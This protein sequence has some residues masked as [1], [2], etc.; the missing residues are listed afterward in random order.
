V[1]FWTHEGRRSV[2]L[3]ISYMTVAGV[4]DGNPVTIERPVEFFLA[5]GQRDMGQQWID[6]SLRM[7]SMAARSGVSVARTIQNMREVNWDKGAVRYGY[8][9]KDDGTKIP[10]FHESEVAALGFAVQEM[11]ANR[12]FLDADGNQVPVWVLAK[13]LAA[14][15]HPQGDAYSDEA[16]Q[17][18][19]S[20]AATTSR[21]RFMPGT[22]KRCP[23]CG[24]HDTHRIDGCSKC[25]NCGT[26]GSCG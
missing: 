25:L 18:E 17:P 16:A 6:M 20:S 15:Q 14:R 8:I 23:T 19:Q 1:V 26:V 4:M 10:R 3:T 12:G 11:L 24:A 2:Y 5:G 9:I 22:G 7:L 21:A 13:H